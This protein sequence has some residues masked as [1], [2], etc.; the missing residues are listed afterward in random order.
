M[1]LKD[2][3]EKAVLQI[4]G[5]PAFGSDEQSDEQGTYISPYT[6]ADRVCKAADALTD[7]TGERFDDDEPDKPP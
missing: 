4:A 7:L 3:W 2:F 1:K 6:W 5:N